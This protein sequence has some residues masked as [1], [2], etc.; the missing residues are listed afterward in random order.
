MT[1]RSRI[2]S[3]AW[4]V[5]PA[6]VGTFVLWTSNTRT[7]RIDHVSG[8]PDWSVAVP[9]EDD[10]SATGYASGTRRLLVPEQNTDTYQWIAQTQQ[11]IAIGDW[12]VRRIEFENAP[13]GRDTLA[14][15]PYRWWLGIV[16]GADHLF[17]GRSLPLSVEQAALKSDV[18][19]HLLLLVCATAFIFRQFGALPA[20]LAAIAIGTIFPFSGGF[21]PGLLSSF[22]L[23]SSFALATILLLLAG[24]W[25]PNESGKTASRKT[26]LFFILSGVAG[27]IGMW[28]NVRSAAPVLLGIF[29]GAVIASFL[30]RGAPMA[31]PWRAWAIAGAA[32]SVA[33]YLIEFFPGHLSIQPGTNNPVMSLAWLGAGELLQRL[34]GWIRSGRSSWTRRDIIATV[35]AVLAI[36]VFPLVV[37]I[38]DGQSVPGADPH[39]TRLS[40]S[41]S[42]RA[43]SFG[44]WLVRDGISNTAI[45]TV[46]PLSFLVLAAGLVAFQKSDPASRATV[47]L[48]LGPAIVT[49]PFACSQLRYWNLVDVALIALLSVTIAATSRLRGTVFV[50]GLTGGGAALLLLAGLSETIPP[51][52]TTPPRPI[53]QTETESLIARDLAHWITNRSAEGDPVVFTSPDLTSSLC[54]FG[55]IRGIGTI[56][57]ENADGMTALIKIASASTD[58]EVMALVEVRKISHIVFPSWDTLLDQ[59]MKLSQQAAG[60]T[61]NRAPTFLGGLRNWNI[62]PW[63]KPVPYHLPKIPGLDAHSIVVFEVVD[64]ENEAVALGR[65]IDYFIE[66][67]MPNRAVALH[68]KL[69]EFSSQVSALIARAQIDLAR[70]DVQSFETTKTNLLSALTSGFNRGLPWDRRVSL[71]ILLADGKDFDRAREQTLLCLNTIDETG[72]RA[73]TPRQIARF[74]SLCRIFEL[75]IDDPDLDRLS[76]SLLPPELAERL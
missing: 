45:V 14:A 17:S 33:G 44:D 46:L 6:L 62:P 65:Q 54:H 55:G 4:L 37:S 48:A 7:E 47:G 34:T 59:F 24:L 42:V 18:A 9:A 57:S 74:R 43:E 35:L 31:P 8:Q 19:L 39:E 49:L 20:S 58:R 15:S 64:E 52:N 68:G 75:R 36:A 27:G 13:Y 2:F 29:P 12:R 70:R 21:L 16:A 56:D 22:A 71:A 60:S 3:H 53:T 30:N 73:L 38:A 63:L 40:P 72:L 28:I 69:R 66:M 11:M 50:R 5:V 32:T 23:E 10:S 26:R 76:L 1:L 67:G 51:A 25:S 41:S 61:Q